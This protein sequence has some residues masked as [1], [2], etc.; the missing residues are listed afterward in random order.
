MFGFQPLLYGENIQGYLVISYCW[1]S[2]FWRLMVATTWSICTKNDEIPK[3]VKNRQEC[4]DGQGNWRQFE[5]EDG[6]WWHVEGTKVLENPI[7]CSEMGWFEIKTSISSIE[8]AGFKIEFGPLSLSDPTSDMNRVKIRRRF[9][10]QSPKSD[11]V[12]LGYKS[13]DPYQYPRANQ[14]GICAIN[15]DVVWYLIQNPIPSDMLLILISKT[16][17]RSTFFGSPR[18]NCRTQPRFG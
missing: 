1:Q 14:G 12:I 17:D 11:V 13:F 18:L 9:T 7:G 8:S 6:R 16:R 10:C 4:G 15:M 2:Q 3:F 5:T